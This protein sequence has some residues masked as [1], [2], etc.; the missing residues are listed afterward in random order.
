V[1][2]VDLPLAAV[3]H[4][5]DDENVAYVQRVWE[6]EPLDTWHGLDSSSGTSATSKLRVKALDTSDNL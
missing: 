5:I 6:G 4:L 1:L 2:V 3:K